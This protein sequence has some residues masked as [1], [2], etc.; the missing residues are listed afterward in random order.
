MLALLVGFTLVL[1]A[2]PTGTA[3]AHEGEPLAPHDLWGAWNR[4]PA[5]WLGI[6]LVGWFY[7]R[8]V[9][10]LWEK[11]GTG[12]GTARWQAAAF[13]GGLLVLVLALVSPLDALSG[14]LFSAHM[15]QHLLLMLVAAPLLTLGTPP[16]ALAWSVP[17]SWRVG[18]GRWWH[19]Q[20]FVRTGWRALRHPLVVWILHAAAL[21][22]WHLPAYYQ[23]A[24]QSEFLHLLEHASFLGTALLFW[25]ILVQ[26]NAHSHF[27]FGIGILYVFSM[28]M[29]SGILGALITFSRQ[30]WYPI[31]AASTTTWGLT[32]LED[33]QLA[34]VL[35]WVPAN[36]IYL[37]A[38]LLLLKA[39]LT[40]MEK[41]DLLE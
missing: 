11:A 18:L 7:G 9:L 26:I 19:N 37:I 17:G 22:V 28:A 10:A 5:I 12:R 36:F 2:L 15:L 23:A 13:T 14:A 31:Y 25:W 30:A 21:L 32:P 33:Q 24:L 35:M 41:R 3:W 6:F 27:S 39:W 29:Y 20:A 38:T 1:L 4:N 34:G 8:G 16:A 40:A